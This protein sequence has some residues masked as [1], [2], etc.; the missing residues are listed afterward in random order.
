VALF[1]LDLDRFKQVNDTMGHP[2]GDALLQ[3]VAQRLVRLVG[4]HGKVGRLGGDEFQIIIAGKLDKLQLARLAEAVIHNISQPYSIEGSQVDIGASVGIAIAPE[5]GSVAE[6][7]TR[8]ADLAL[9]AAKGDGRGVF[10]F[11]APSMHSEAEVRRQLEQ[12]LR[13]ALVTG[14]LH[15]AYQPVVCAS[16]ERITGYEALL[17]WNHPTKGAISPALFIPIAEDAGLIASIGEWVMRTACAEAA[18]WPSNVRIAVNVS[19]IQFA[20]PSFPAL[21]MNAL[22]STGL[23]PER[24]EL[25]IT[26][27]VFMSQGADTDGM[28]ASLKAIG[29]R[30]ALDDFGTGYSSLGYLKTAPFDKIKIDQSF[31]RG[32]AI[33]G[34]RNAAIVKAI[35]SLAEALGMETTAEGAETMDELALIRS[36][37][38]SHVQGYVYGRP[39][40]A[41]LARETLAMRQGYASPIG[42]KVSREPRQTILRRV[43]LKH[44]A[45]TYSARIRNIS[46]GGA[47]IEGLTGV[48]S[49]TTFMVEVSE[50]LSV[51]GAVRWSLEDRLGIE[52]EHPIDLEVLRGASEC[53]AAG[54]IGLPRTVNVPIPAMPPTTVPLQPSPNPLLPGALPERR[55]G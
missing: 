43:I 1:M 37:G 16:T 30:L 6:T 55:T 39:V 36:L 41:A 40:E 3:Q 48:P 54:I 33:R 44:G 26:E 14:G 49:G 42:L 19:P 4:T 25:E 10:R 22:A 9:Y 51:K 46:A 29:V 34:S 28:F 20:N 11:Y 47:M 18:G 23:E 24:L 50:E 27:S 12:D 2:A 32:A 21:V 35:V 38:C 53:G 52:F 31:V 45:R 17:R 7:L 5:D 13:Q 15:M 8:N